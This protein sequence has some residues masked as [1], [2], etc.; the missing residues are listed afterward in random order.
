M[1]IFEQIHTRAHRFLKDFLDVE[2]IIRTNQ[3]DLRSEKIRQLFLKYGTLDLYE[4]IVRAC[5]DS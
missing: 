3:V 2:G 1:A 4:K 5:S